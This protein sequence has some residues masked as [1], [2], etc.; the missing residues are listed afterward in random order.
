MVTP[1]ANVT[2]YTLSSV[3]HG[4]K[5]IATQSGRKERKWAMLHEHTNSFNTGIHNIHNTY[6]EKTMQ[7]KYTLSS[8]YTKMHLLTDLCIDKMAVLR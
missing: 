8:S 1:M 3:V 6:R 5:A 2:C 4:C 7:L